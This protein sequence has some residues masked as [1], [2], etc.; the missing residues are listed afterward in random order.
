MDHMLYN[1]IEK[2]KIKVLS[3]CF[4]RFA[5]LSILFCDFEKCEKSNMVLSFN[6]TVLIFILPFISTPSMF[7]PTMLE[8][9]IS[10]DQ[11]SSVFSAPRFFHC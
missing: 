5:R 3:F 7:S 6:S 11:F 10:I 4:T 2:V 9:Y 8:I 1:R